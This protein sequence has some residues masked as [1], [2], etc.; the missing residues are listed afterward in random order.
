M[1]FTELEAILLSV[2]FVKQM[3]VM[4]SKNCH[5]CDDHQRHF[6]SQR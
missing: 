6:F 5:P 2:L 3:H 4:P 1:I